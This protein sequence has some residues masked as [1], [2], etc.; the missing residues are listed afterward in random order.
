MEAIDIRWTIRNWIGNHF[1]Q[2]ALRVSKNES[3]EFGKAVNSMFSKLYCQECRQFIV[4]S[5]TPKGQ[6]AC[7]KGELLY[8][9]TGKEAIKPI[10]RDDLISLTRGIL[11]DAQL[12]TDVYFDWKK[13]EIRQEKN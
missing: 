11:K 7:R 9:E 10:S 13:A 8:P 5:V 3:I 6:L 1:N 12:N 2:W 4:P